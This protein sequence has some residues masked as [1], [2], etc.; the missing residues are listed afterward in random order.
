MARPR[1][2]E[3]KEAILDAARAILGS[4]GFAATTINQIARYAGVSR[5]LLHYYFESKEDLLNRTVERNMAGSLRLVAAVFTE[6]STALDLAARLANALRVLA[7]HDPAFFGLLFECWLLARR[8]DPPGPFS[9]LFNR[10]RDTM[11]A[12][13]DEA[14]NAGLVDAGLDPVATAALLVAM[15][16]GLALQILLDADLG[17]SQPLWD[18]FEGQVHR[19]LTHP[20]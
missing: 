12:Q 6:C 20:E 4:Q 19:L 17:T 18:T 2:D 1:S 5:G 8:E 7:R 13:L 9:A 3:K 11:A 14:R 15:M 16:H 10:F